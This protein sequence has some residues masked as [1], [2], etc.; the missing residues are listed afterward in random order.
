M[1]A[2]VAKYRITV[3]MN[4]LMT[5]PQRESNGFFTCN[6]LAKGIVLY[7]LLSGASERLVFQNGTLL[8]STGI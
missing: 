6:L 3:R 1:I 2:C 4:P 8:V 5:V 7:F